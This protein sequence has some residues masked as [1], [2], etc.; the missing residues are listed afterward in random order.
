MTRFR[1]RSK[2]SGELKTARVACVSATIAEISK[3]VTRLVMDT[4]LG[5]RHPILLQ[6]SRVSGATP[7]IKAKIAGKIVMM[8][9]TRP[10][11]ESVI[12]SVRSE[13]ELG[14]DKCR[15]WTPDI[16]STK[17]ICRSF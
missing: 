13:P 11:G 9:G 16:G 2:W 14:T 8:T 3:N 1:P 17:S 15:R 10:W 4:N 7:F 12:I 5:V 6:V